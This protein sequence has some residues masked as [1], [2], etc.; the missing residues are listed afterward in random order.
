MFELVKKHNADT[1]Q[2]SW[3]LLRKLAATESSVVQQKCCW[4]C[5]R[6]CCCCWYCPVDVDADPVDAVA[7]D[8]AGIQVDPAAAVL[9][10]DDVPADADAGA[11]AGAD[12][13]LLHILH[14]SPH[15]TANAA[16]FSQ[17]ALSPRHSY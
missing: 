10:A 6:Y 2:F 8:A 11:D 4:Y 3:V 16:A 5:C 7:A 1:S 9:E 12:A 13:P 17:T 15:A 14:L